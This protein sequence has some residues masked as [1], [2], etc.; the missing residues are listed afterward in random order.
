M[1]HDLIEQ[2]AY[3]AHG[4]C[5]LWKPWL[6]ALHAGSDL[7]IAAAYFA[8]PLAIFRFER[9]RVRWE[10]SYVAWL[11]FAFIALCGL[12]HFI[13]VLTL[14]QPIYEFEGFVKLA[15]AGVSFA[16]AVVIYP[17]VPAMAALPSPRPFR[18][19]TRVSKAKLPPIARRSPNSSRC[20][21]IWPRRSS[22]EPVRSARRKSV[23]RRS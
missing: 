5:L 18:K 10:F 3:M 13:S 23:S 9:V 1:V 8:I 12:T 21:P 11:F 14:W 15:T 19:P 16:T 4:Y 6:V 2:A 20:A 7:V 22:S 17:L